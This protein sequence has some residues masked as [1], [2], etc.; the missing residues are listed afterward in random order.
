MRSKVNVA[1]QSDCA[2]G[3]G[4]ARLD[5][6]YSASRWTRFE[7]V[8]AWTAPLTW[9]SAV[10]FLAD[11]EVTI[12]WGNESTC[13]IFASQSDKWLGGALQLNELA[14]LAEPPVA[15]N[16]LDNPNEP[17]VASPLP[18][19]GY[20]WVAGPYSPPDLQGQ[21]VRTVSCI[22]HDGN[23][24]NDTFCID[25]SIP[26]DELWRPADT[27]TSLPLTGKIALIARGVCT[28][29]NKGKCEGRR[30]P[31]KRLHGRGA[32]AVPFTS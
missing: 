26:E 20:S 16:P 19:E 10:W 2:P 28:F 6:G 32:S 21:R 29:V 9:H 24:V 5:E 27:T 14:E 7:A 18:E 13:G 1:Q 12:S 30:L 8:F 22:A 3:R 17:N 11:C 15:C 23:V 31:K 4:R 25:P